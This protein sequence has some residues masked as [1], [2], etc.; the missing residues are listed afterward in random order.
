MLLGKKNGR[1]QVTTINNIFNYSY[2]L[3]SFLRFRDFILDNDQWKFV[4]NSDDD[5]NKD[6]PIEESF[7]YMGFC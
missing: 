4:E 7:A 6:L 5:N 1:T 3:T 2:H